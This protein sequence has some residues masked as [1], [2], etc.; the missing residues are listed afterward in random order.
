MLV[1]RAIALAIAALAM[2]ILSPACADP[3]DVLRACQ[4]MVNRA[5]QPAQDA[6][7]K[8]DD[9]EVARCRQVIRD[10]TLRDSR[11]NVDED[12]RPLR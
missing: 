8:P 7:A 2:A 12:G 3:R 11:M 6:A 1:R 5:A 4:A 9:V 10:W